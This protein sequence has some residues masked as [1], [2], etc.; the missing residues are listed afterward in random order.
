[1]TIQA[2]KPGDIARDSRTG[3]IGEIREVARFISG[4][5]AYLRPQGGGT[6][7]TAPITALRPTQTPGGD[8]AG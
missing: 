8:T 7:W 4:P 5:A 2:W 1:M 6:E 3:R